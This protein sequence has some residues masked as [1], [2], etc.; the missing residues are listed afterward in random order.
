MTAPALVFAWISCPHAPALGSHAYVET[1]TSRRKATVI[2]T[3]PGAALLR[4]HE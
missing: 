1:P 4:W 2:A 3:K